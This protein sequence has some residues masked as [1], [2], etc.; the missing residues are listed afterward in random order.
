MSSDK[1]TSAAEIRTLLNRLELE[2]IEA[3]DVGLAECAAFMNELEHDI[4][5]C[6][7]MFVFTAVT[8]IAVLRA[9]LSGPMLG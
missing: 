4:A 9:E 3:K 6:R 2:R 7:S 5:A 1:Q 8:E